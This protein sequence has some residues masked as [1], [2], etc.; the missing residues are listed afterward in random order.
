[1]L[2]KGGESLLRSAYAVADASPALGLAR[3][4]GV[5]YLTS[6][7]LLFETPESRGAV[8]DFVQGKAV[9]LAL[10][11]ALPDL[12]NASVRRGRVARPR[13][14]LEF[15]AGR[16][17]FDVLDPDAWLGQI[18]MARRDLPSTSAGPSVYTV[19]RPVIKVRCRFCGT[20]GHEG[21]ARCPACGAPL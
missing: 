11:T 16:A 10:D 2:L 3:G 13:L 6:H 7:R 18:A 20:L 4:P 9:R 19:E 12:R 14:V 21:D 17:A 5:L 1:M 15:A 8:R